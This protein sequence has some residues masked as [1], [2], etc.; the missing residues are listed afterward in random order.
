MLFTKA[1]NHGGVRDLPGGEIPG[2]VTEVM[3]GDDLEHQEHT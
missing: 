2:A 3:T 1:A